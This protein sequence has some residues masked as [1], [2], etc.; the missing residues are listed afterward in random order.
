MFSKPDMIINYK[1]ATKKVE[2]EG[3]FTVKL[4]LIALNIF[5][6]SL[7]FS[8]MIAKK[9]FL[10]VFIPVIVLFTVINILVYTAN[11]KLKLK[12]KKIDFNNFIKNLFD[13]DK[14]V[15]ALI[16]YNE[17]FNRKSEAKNK[18][19]HLVNAYKNAKELKIIDKTVPA[20]EYYNLV[21]FLLTKC[22]FDTPE[23]KFPYKI[24]L[25]RNIEDNF[26][27]TSWCPSYLMKISSK[28]NEKIICFPK[29]EFLIHVF[30]MTSD[31]KKVKETKLF[32]SLF[33]DK[34][35]KIVKLFRNS[36][37]DSKDVII[38]LKQYY[39]ALKL[40]YSIHKND[41]LRERQILKSVYKLNNRGNSLFNKTGF[42]DL[43]NFSSNLSDGNFISR[44]D[45]TLSIYYILVM[46]STSYRFYDI[47]NFLIKH[48]CDN[49]NEE[50]F[51]Y[52]Q[53]T[54]IGI[55]I[56][57]CFKSL[58]TIKKIIYYKTPSNYKSTQQFISDNIDF[59]LLNAI[60]FFEKFY[61][62]NYIITENEIE[63]R[64]IFD[65]FSSYDFYVFYC[66]LVEPEGWLKKLIDHFEY[67][68]K[69]NTK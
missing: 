17:F 64:N 63:N 57:V 30:N 25:S 67:Q 43:N 27:L 13:K 61:K 5:F 40:H 69:N 41:N 7:L 23:C 66:T 32:L 26:D 34:P 14:S 38:L 1:Y 44:I 22:E 68:F 10:F 65:F 36:S 8:F 55:N 31:I 45:I 16:V 51:P 4:L 15:S 62:D 37:F 33:F 48:S 2:A 19:I 11:L 59:M 24:E 58:K 47:W 29:E 35:D 12:S 28:V 54:R 49:L 21:I 60:R 20:L 9:N 50:S 6:T 52:D 46:C 56:T 39:N 53:F 18:N 3:K 42:R